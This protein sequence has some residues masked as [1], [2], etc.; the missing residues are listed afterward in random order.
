MATDIEKTTPPHEAGAEV[1]VARD[2]KG[3]GGLDVVPM[4]E[5]AVQD[6][7]HVHLTWRSWVCMGILDG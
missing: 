3:A 5:E 2:R 7:V 6:V 1:A 4:E